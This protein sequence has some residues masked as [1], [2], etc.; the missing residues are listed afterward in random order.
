MAD[1]VVTCGCM[2][3]R[4]C[5]N[6]A[7]TYPCA[8]H[9]PELDLI[10]ITNDVIV[11]RFKD[12]QQQEL[13]MA[14]KPLCTCPD[15]RWDS[16][17]EH[18]PDCPVVRTLG[19]ELEAFD[20]AESVEDMD[21]KIPEHPLGLGSGS[22]PGLGRPSVDS[23]SDDRT[24]NNVMRHEYRVLSDDEKAQMKAIK[25]KGFE[26]I[27]YLHAIG[28]TS[29]AFDEPDDYDR[30]TGQYAPQGSR[31]LALAATNIEQAVM[32]GVKHVTR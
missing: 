18:H 12:T 5:P 21:Q 14:T 31:E 19:K 29:D 27:R 16:N 13:E 15:S 26:F 2:D 1:V 9:M 28:G 17:S 30:R 10:R 6:G 22:L 24:V 4:D 7:K 3:I 11:A 8:I 25:D 23:A 32:W 20:S